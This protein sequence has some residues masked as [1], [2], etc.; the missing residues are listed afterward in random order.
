MA[1]LPYAENFRDLLAYQK[2]R[3][4]AREIFELTKQF[5]REDYCLLLT[6]HCSL[7]TEPGGITCPTQILS[8]SLASRG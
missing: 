3:Q 6:A 2:S 5:P 7:L 8:T 1:R 4:L